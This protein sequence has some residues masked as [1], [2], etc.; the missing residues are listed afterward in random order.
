MDTVWGGRFVSETAVTSR[1]KQIRR[2]L[3]DDGHAQAAIRTVRGRGYRYVGHRRRSRDAAGGRAATG[4]L[5][6]E[7]RTPRRRTRS[8]DPGISTWC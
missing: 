1:I 5:H 3:G 8:P 6:R 2:A 4:A 7:R